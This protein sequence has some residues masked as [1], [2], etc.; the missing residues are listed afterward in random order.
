MTYAA[1]KFKV[2]AVNGLGEDTI[3]RNRTHERTHTC[4]DRRMDRLRRTYFGTKLMYLF[5][6]R[7]S[8]YKM[9]IL[10][11]ILHLNGQLVDKPYF[12]YKNIALKVIK[13]P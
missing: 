13:N 9:S 5:S 4:I 2:A 8:G 6:T 10:R 7:K 1:T 12:F 3:T 11:I